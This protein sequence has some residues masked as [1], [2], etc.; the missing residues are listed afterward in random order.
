MFGTVNGL[1]G[2]RFGFIEREGEKMYCTFSAI[3][4][5]YKSLEEGQRVEFDIEK[6]PR[7]PGIKCK[8]II[9]I[10][11]HGKCP[12]TSIEQQRIQQK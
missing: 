4:E 10:L 7:G 9:L 11:V 1:S 12:K 2:K 8:I 5:G 3:T 6:G